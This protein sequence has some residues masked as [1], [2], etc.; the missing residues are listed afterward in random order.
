MPTLPSIAPAPPCN[1][2]AVIDRFRP[3]ISRLLALP[4]TRQLEQLARTIYALSEP[5]HIVSKRPASATIHRNKE[6]TILNANLWHDWPRHRDLQTRLEAFA[7]LVEREKAD[8]ILLQEVARTRDF[9]ANDWLAKNLNMGYHYVR[10]N[11]HL[12]TIGFEEGVAIFSRYS[13]HT[14][15]VQQLGKHCNPFTRRLALQVEVETCFGNFLAYS[16]HLGLLPQ[17]NKH[18]IRHLH[19]WVKESGANR[20]AIIGGDFNVDEETLQI[21]Q[22]QATWLDTF[23]HLHPDVSGTTH[24]IRLPWGRSFQRKR[25]DYIFLKP[26]QMQWRVLNAEHLFTPI[27]PHSDHKAVVVRLAPA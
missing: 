11:G 16:T 8:L 15:R 21:Q 12:E 26:G 13:L 19:S 9:H 23:R 5:P 7:E 6:L 27:S 10:A 14:P 18:Q 17:Q 25:L 4:G 20:M 2:Q 22:V 3:V 1:P 24:E